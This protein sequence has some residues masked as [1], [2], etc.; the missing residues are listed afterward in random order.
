MPAET[1][2]L[3]GPPRWRQ[4]SLRQLLAGMAVV[5]GSLALARQLDAASWVVLTV[6]LIPVALTLWETSGRAWLGTLAGALVGG[7]GVLPLAPPSG[8]AF[9]A[10]LAAWL[11]GALHALALGHYRWGT[12]VLILALACLVLVLGPPLGRS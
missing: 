5:G 6:M 11:G 2:T 3:P 7:L 1:P 4:F 12:L 8:V 10:A 9:V